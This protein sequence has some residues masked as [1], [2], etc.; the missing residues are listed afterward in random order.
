MAYHKWLL[1]SICFVLFLFYNKEFSL[2][3]PTQE[4]LHTTYPSLYSLYDKQYINNLKLASSPLTNYINNRKLQTQNSTSQSLPTTLL[5]THSPLLGQISL[6][7]IPLM[8]L[9]YLYTTHQSNTGWTPPNT[10]HTTPHNT[11]ILKEL[12]QNIIH[13]HTNIIHPTLFHTLDQLLP[14]THTHTNPL[15]TSMCIPTPPT[16]IITYIGHAYHTTHTYLQL[17]KYILI[18]HY[19]WNNTI[20]ILLSETLDTHPDTLT[21]PLPT[22]QK[23]YYFKTTLYTHHI[24]YFQWCFLM[25]YNL[26]VIFYYYYHIRYQHTPWHPHMSHKQAHISF[27]R[28]NT[29]PHTTINPY[30]TNIIQCLIPTNQQRKLKI[31]IFLITICITF[32]LIFY[33]V[34]PTHSQHVHKVTLAY[35][36]LKYQAPIILSQTSGTHT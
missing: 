5:T 24:T 15:F 22:F 7:P 28:I 8:W 16:Q 14:S 6:T 29:R 21:Q 18:H 17:Q 2:P 9:N 26:L 25:A 3:F 33:Q 23:V 12:P 11:P 34:N 31:I 13:I 32:T 1:L 19:T 36:H 20:S 30:I 10:Y 35:G 27:I 4:C